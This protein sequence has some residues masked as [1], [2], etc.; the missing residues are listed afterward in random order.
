MYVFAGKS[1]GLVKLP[2]QL[3]YRDDKVVLGTEALPLTE[4]NNPYVPYEAITDKLP[5][6]NYKFGIKSV[7]NLENFSTVAQGDVTIS[8]FTMF[9]RFISITKLE[10]PHKARL[11]WTAPISGVPDTYKLYSNRGDGTYTFTLFTTLVGN[12]LTT[13][14]LLNDGNWAFKIEAVKD[15]IESSN[16]FTASIEI[17][18]DIAKPPAP[19]DS[20]NQVTSVNA[21]NSNAG[22]IE[23]SFLWIYGASAK[24]FRL[25]HD[26][27][28]GTIYWNS[29]YEFT[30]I[31]GYY[32]KFTTPQIYDGETDAEFRFVVRAV[33]PYGIEDS[34]AEEHT[35]MLDGAAPSIPQSLTLSTRM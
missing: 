1:K 8:A 30:R 27:G 9:P 32:Q 25:Y 17:P 15:G 19:F 4:L 35:V 34:N 2:N 24:T 28:T 26:R 22:K 18:Y 23:F 14:V 16:S 33:S 7:D 11:T 10:N 20:V 3:N 12:V 5:S 31:N 13:D 29:F 6:G 21:K